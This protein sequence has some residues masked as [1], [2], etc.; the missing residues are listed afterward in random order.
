MDVK[1]SSRLQRSRDTRFASATLT[2]HFKKLGA[3]LLPGLMIALSGCGTNRSSTSGTNTPPVSGNWQFA[4]TTPAGVSFV[5]S[6]LEGGFLLQKNGSLS[7]QVVFALTL[8]GQN[9]GNPTVCNSGTATVTGTVSGQT[10]NLAATVGTLDQNGNPATQAI[11]LSG[12]MLSTDNLSIQNGTYSLTPGF[13]IPSTGTNPAPCGSVQDAGTWSA[14][15]VP[16]L[17]GSFQGFFHSSSF[18]QQD[19]PVSGTFTE[20]ENIGTSFATVTGTLLFQDPVTLLNDYPCLTTASVNGE[21]SGN[22]VTLQ[23]Y[24]SNGLVAG[25]IGG[26]A[27]LFPATFN[28]N[29]TGGLLLQA[30]NGYS[31]ANKACAKDVGNL[32]FAFGSSKGCTQPIVLTPLSLIFP[33]NPLFLSPPPLQVLGSPASTQTVTI[34]NTTGSPLDGVTVQPISPSFEG[35]LL[36]YGSPVGGGDFNGNPSFTI[37]QTGQASDCTTLAPPGSAFTLQTSCTVTV[38]FAPQESCPWMPAAIGGAS[39]GPPFS[40]PPSLCPTPVSNR[41]FVNTPATS[42]KDSDG[43]FSLPLTGNAVSAILPSTGE[44]DFGSEAVGEVSPPQT[45]TFTNDSPNPVQV[46]PGANTCNTLSQLTLPSPLKLGSSIPGFNFSLAGFQVDRIGFPADPITHNA[47]T[48]T[49]VLATPTSPA[50]VI[51]FCDFDSQ[52]RQTNFQIAPPPA[53][54]CLGSSQGILLQP[55]QS[56]TLQITFAPQSEA[57]STVAATNTVGLDYFLQLNTV[58]CSSGESNCEIDSGR[59]PVELKTEPPSS[60]RLTPGAGMEFGL[61]PKGMTSNPLSITLFNDP[62]D[63]NSAPVNFTAKFTSG[64]YFETDNCPASLAPNNS[65]TITVTLTPKVAGLDPGTLTITYNTPT[66]T[67]L[68][69]TIYMRGTGQ[70]L[71]P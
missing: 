23:I 42:T 15:S 48:I 46:L 39:P 6:P 33:P 16:P 58:Q 18:K 50:T 32:C 20:G 4:M 53:S 29:T 26:S 7:G 65:C 71:A 68:V 36:F 67:G 45:L 55:Q 59:F 3:W 28:N 25:Q 2:A 41:L 24:G 19:F 63:P 37:L 62:A 13:Y 35:S 61:V 31:V 54:T 40:E 5:S 47:A 70:T 12:G 30:Q 27:P 17:T 66:Q 49:P 10:V 21:I 44:L 22:N 56:C 9:G 38:Q 52:S 34:T 11:S 64:D 57:W 14:T 43:T 60:L 51:F 69:Q 8:A 1:I